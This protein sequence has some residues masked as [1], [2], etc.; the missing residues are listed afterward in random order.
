MNGY[1]ISA[2]IFVFEQHLHVKFDRIRGEKV[3]VWL[4]NYMQSYAV[5]YIWFPY[6]DWLSY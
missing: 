6:P 5:A 4:C 1:L 2:S 3:Y